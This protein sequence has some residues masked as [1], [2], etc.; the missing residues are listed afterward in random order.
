[1]I[2]FDK[3]LEVRKLQH[4]IFM[5]MPLSKRISISQNMCDMSRDLIRKRL[6]KQGYSGKELKLQFLKSLYPDKPQEYF[7]TI[8]EML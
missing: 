5:A 6:I 7:N 4:N 2:K 1:M 8:Q 3:P